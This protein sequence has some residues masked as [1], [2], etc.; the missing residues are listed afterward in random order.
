MPRG[1]PEIGTIAGVFRCAEGFTDSPRSDSCW[2][3]ATNRV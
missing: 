2:K 1:L 3:T